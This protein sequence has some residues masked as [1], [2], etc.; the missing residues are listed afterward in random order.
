[1]LSKTKDLLSKINLDTERLNTL[2]KFPTNHSLLKENVQP[3][4]TQPES[5]LKNMSVYYNAKNDKKN[6]YHPL[7][8]ASENK[9][10]YIK[11]SPKKKRNS[12]I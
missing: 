11:Q 2:A 10:I 4:I 7:E 3:P 8:N 9:D 12:Q 5:P 6:N 1:M